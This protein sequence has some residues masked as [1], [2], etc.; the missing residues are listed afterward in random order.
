VFT[1]LEA[2]ELLAGVRAEVVAAGGVYGAEGCV[3]LALIGTEEQ[4]RKA[5]ALLGEIAPEPLF[6]SH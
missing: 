6:A 2:V 1:E 3:W 4:T 5:A